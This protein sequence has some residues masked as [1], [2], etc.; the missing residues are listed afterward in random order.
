MLI[1]RSLTVNW[2]IFHFECLRA[3]CYSN[4]LYYCFISS[5]VYLLILSQHTDSL[6]LG[7]CWTNASCLAICC[8]R[9]VLME[10]RLGKPVYAVDTAQNGRLVAVAGAGSKMLLSVL[11]W[12]VKSLLRL[13]HIY[14]PTFIF[15]WRLVP[16]PPLFPTFLC[17]FFSPFTPFL[18]HKM[19]LQ[20]IQ[21]ILGVL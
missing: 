10:L 20:Y 1:Q 4:R 5:I 14:A 8:S 18:C 17:S 9:Q 11:S 19:A 2:W 21:G 13:N 6:V 3:H 16:A 12:L 7:V 15:L